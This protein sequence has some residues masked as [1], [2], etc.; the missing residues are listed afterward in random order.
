MHRDDFFSDT[1]LEDVE[2]WTSA[3]SEAE[4]KPCIILYS[5]PNCPMCQTLKQLLTKARITFIVED[6]PLILAKHNIYHVPVLSINE[7][8]LT[9]PEALRW[10]KTNEYSRQ[11]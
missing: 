8:H 7:Q 3:L 10:V 6:D 11:N 5:L 4:Q 9:F 1:S 2:K